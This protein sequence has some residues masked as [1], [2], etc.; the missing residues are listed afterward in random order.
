[1]SNINTIYARI[2]TKY[3]EDGGTD[4]YVYIGIGGRE[5]S[6]D[7]KRTADDDFE[8]GAEKTYVLGEEPNPFPTQATTLRNTK[9]Q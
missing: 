9:Y 3:I 8:K 4:G 5:F 1:M 7:S 6:I 2:V